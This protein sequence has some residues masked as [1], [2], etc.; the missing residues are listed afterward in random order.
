MTDAVSEEVK[1]WQARP[2]DA[3][4]PIV[5]LDCIH[6]KGYEG[7]VRIK[8]VYLVI[9]INLAGEK[10]VL[11]LWLAQTEGVKFWL[12]VVTEL[13]NRGVQDIFIACVDGLRGFPDAIE[14]VFPKVVVQ[15]CI[16]HMVRHSLNDVSWK[17]RKDVATDL[18]RIYQAATAEEAEL[19]LGE[20][21]AK[22][23]ADYLPIG[24]SWRR[25]WS[26]LTPFFDYPAEIRKVV[27]TTNAIESVN[28]GLRKLR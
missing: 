14:A 26:R 10:E 23:G 1:V 19:P 17:R 28:M 12:Q 16:V 11:G 3:I 20:F 25:N 21:E 5:Y 7:A 13:R 24:Q 15:L 22:W 8:A 4:Y 27:Y 18:R 6:V 2:L 9:G